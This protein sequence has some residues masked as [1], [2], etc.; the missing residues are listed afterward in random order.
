LRCEEWKVVKVN[1]ASLWVEEWDNDSTSE[2][3]VSREIKVAIQ[4]VREAKPHQ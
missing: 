2:D 3:Q 1:K 4:K